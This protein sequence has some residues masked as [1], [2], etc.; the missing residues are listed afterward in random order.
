M[1]QN[2]RINISWYHGDAYDFWKA[3]PSF[4]MQHMFILHYAWMCT[5]ILFFVAWMLDSTRRPVFDMVFLNME[6]VTFVCSI[7][8]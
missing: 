3:M 4:E 8:D 5:I 2:A 6:M 7:D 1:D